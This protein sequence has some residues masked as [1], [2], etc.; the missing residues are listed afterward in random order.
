[1]RRATLL[2]LVALLVWSCASAKTDPN[3]NPDCKITAE[4]AQQI[5][6]AACSTAVSA[7]TNCTPSGPSGTGAMVC[8][9]GSIGAM[10]PGAKEPEHWTDPS[11]EW[12]ATAPGSSAQA[13]DRRSESIVMPDGE[14]AAVVWCEVNRQHRSVIYATLTRGPITRA[15]ARYFRDQGM[16]AE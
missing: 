2:A 3:N 8:D 1:M 5:S 10:E 4:S 16:C 11:M 12:H 7:S 6:L 14:I 13:T 9:T 15:Q